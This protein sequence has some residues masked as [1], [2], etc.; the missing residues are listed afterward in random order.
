MRQLKIKI[1]SGLAAGTL[2]LAMTVPAIAWEGRS[3]SQRRADVRQEIQQDRARLHQERQELQ[4]SRRELRHDLRRGASRAEIARDRADFREDRRDV[5]D[6]RR[7][8]NR[9][10]N[11]YHARYGGWY[12]YSRWNRDDCYWRGDG[13]RCY[14]S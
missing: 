6:A 3:S 4:Q 9:D 2:V 11:E 14:R 10:L 5:R 8:L 12:P 1:L 13:W 7:E